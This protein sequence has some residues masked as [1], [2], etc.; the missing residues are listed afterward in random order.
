MSGP[1]VTSV[2]RQTVLDKAGGQVVIH[3]VEVFG[4]VT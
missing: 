2:N 3:D 4:F 1:R